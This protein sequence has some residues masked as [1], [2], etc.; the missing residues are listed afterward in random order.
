MVWLVAVE[1]PCRYVAAI[2]L[3]LKRSAFIPTVDRHEIS[4]PTPTV[5]FPHR[6]HLIDI[7]ECACHDE[8]IVESRETEIRCHLAAMYKGLMVPFLYTCAPF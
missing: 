2:R 1:G 3:D 5:L 6:R 8:L 4:G 7:D